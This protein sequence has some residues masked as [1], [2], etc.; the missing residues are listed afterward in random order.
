MTIQELNGILDEIGLPYA[1]YQFD[2]DTPQQLPFICWMITAHNDFM[3]DGINYTEIVHL[4][5]EL[6]TNKKD[7][8]TEQTVRGVL[9]SHGIPFTQDGTEI[10][11][12]G[13]HL[14]TFVTEFVMTEA[15]PETTTQ[16]DNNDMEVL[17]NGGE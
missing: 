16:A 12:E 13:M 14:E 7:F 9:T 5:I 6:Y 15:A 17:E 8:V 10:D 11:S 4:V 2:D 3:A 1:Y